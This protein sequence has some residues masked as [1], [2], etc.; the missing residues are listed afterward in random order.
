MQEILKDLNIEVLSNPEAGIKEDVPETGE[1]FAENAFIKAG[2][3]AKKTG[4]WSISDDSGICIKALN[5]KPGVYS[6]RWAGEGAGDEELV[7]FTLDRMKNI[8]EGKRQAYF[9]SSAVIVSPQGKTWTFSGSINGCIAKTPKG[10]M[11]K[12]LPY[13]VIFIP[14][15][16]KQTFAQMTQAEKNSLSHRGKAFGKLKDFIQI[17]LSK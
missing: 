16:F 12:G 13:D 8:P 11:E 6:A 9:E 2:F 1:T 3:A 17:N 14:E 5:D 7:N 10:K 15:G 4:K